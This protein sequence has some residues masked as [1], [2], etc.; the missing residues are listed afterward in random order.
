MMFKHF[1]K[2]VAAPILMAASMNLQAQD[3]SSYDVARLKSSWEVVENGYEGKAQFLSSFTFIN[4]GNKPFPAK[5][6]QLYFNFVRMVKPGQQLN[7]VTI[8]HVNGDLF[9]VVPNAD[10][11]GIA[12]GDSLKVNF[13]SEAWAINFTDGPK[14]L[15]VVWNQQPAKG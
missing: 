14:G 13:S 15:Y 12:P 4:T 8:E 7:G 3:N 10:F 11:K 1:S 6:W 5:N 2:L 9:R